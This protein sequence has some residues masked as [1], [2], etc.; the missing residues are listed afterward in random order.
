MFKVSNLR[1]KWQ[2]QRIKE[3]RGEEMDVRD[4]SLFFNFY[5][6]PF[7]VRHHGIRKFPG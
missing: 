3:E 5:F 2:L 1:L 7:L 6:F 4:I